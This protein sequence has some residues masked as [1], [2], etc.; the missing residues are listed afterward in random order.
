MRILEDEVGDD[1]TRTS[2]AGTPSRGLPHAPHVQ[3]QLHESV[4]MGAEDIR[5][6]EDEVSDEIADSNRADA[7]T[8]GQHIF[9]RRGQFRPYETEGLALL[10]HEATHVLNALRPNAAWR[11]ATAAGLQEE[12]RE[13]LAREQEVRA[14]LPGQIPREPHSRS[15]A[16]RDGAGPAAFDVH[17]TLP[18]SWQAR[19][20]SPTLQPMRAD[21]G[22]K[23]DSTGSAS[24]V[25]HFNK[26]VVEQILL[27]AIRRQIERGV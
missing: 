5:I 3:A 8:V 22:R 6:H 1:V 23:L 15:I 26:D 24:P 25:P 10:A 17:A 9:F 19:P 2:R 20:P 14:A 12:E 11:R 7:V 21:V 27:D 13:A 16:A 18:G 4:E